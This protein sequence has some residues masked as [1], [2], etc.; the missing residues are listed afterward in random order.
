MTLRE[1]VGG[2]ALALA[3]WAFLT[4]GTLALGY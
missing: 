4:L 3:L 2:F 1:L